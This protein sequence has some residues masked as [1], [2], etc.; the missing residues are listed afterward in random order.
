MEY[1]HVIDPS[2]AW[3]EGWGWF[4]RIRG[5]I[6]EVIVSLCLIAITHYYQL[7]FKIVLFILLVG[8]F[9][10]IILLI[11][12]NERMREARMGKCIHTL[13]H[14]IRDEAVAILD[15]AL[16][17]NPGYLSKYENFHRDVAE[18][19]AAYYT[20]S[21]NDIT[22]NCAIRLA[23]ETKLDGMCKQSYVTVGRSKGMDDSRAELSVP[24]PS[25]KGVALMLRQ[26]QSK[27]V[28]ICRDISKAIREGVWL[29]TP[30]DELPDVK[31]VMI[32]P[33]NGYVDV[34][35]EKSMLGLLYVTSTEDV[36]RQIHVEPL[37]AIA[38]VLGFVYPIVT[39][40]CQCTKEEARKCQDQ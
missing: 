28:Y 37:K 5:I 32:A 25:D 15:K 3:K 23:K 26:K 9:G 35:R 2:E 8:A 7:N 21:L 31:T 22:I 40:I 12:R 17:N 30:T 18:R 19:V 34:G 1:H 11:L 24:I 29:E 27:G 4:L 10:F 13:Y 39:G 20:H 14:N 6:T 16:S 36:F 38:D 33:I